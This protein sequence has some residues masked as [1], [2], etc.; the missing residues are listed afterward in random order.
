M[1][2]RPAFGQQQAQSSGD[3]AGKGS[4]RGLQFMHLE[5][6]LTGVNTAIVPDTWN[7]LLSR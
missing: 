5:M 7:P 6:D 4:F 2:R 1:W 3:L